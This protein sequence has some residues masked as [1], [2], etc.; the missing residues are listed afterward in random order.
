PGQEDAAAHGVEVVTLLRRNR[1][2]QLAGR[3][4]SGSVT[5]RPSR[6]GKKVVYAMFGRSKEAL[7]DGGELWSVIQKKQGAASAKTKLADLFST[8]DLVY[9]KKGYYVFRA[10]NI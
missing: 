6:A 5:R 3:A 4:V 10:I 1:C 8:V 2:S 7:W 9:R